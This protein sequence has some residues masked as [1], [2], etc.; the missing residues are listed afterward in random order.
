MAGGLDQSLIQNPPPLGAA[1]SSP[2]RERGAAVAGGGWRKSGGGCGTPL[3]SRVFGAILSTPAPA[4]SSHRVWLKAPITPCAEPAPSRSGTA[5]TGSSP[6][7][8]TR[9]LRS[10]PCWAS[11][12][13]SAAADANAIHTS[14]F[15]VFLTLS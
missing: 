14:L 8:L 5:I 15:I 4:R 12:V 7:L 11:T 9:P 1:T 13:I 6:A 10:G 2:C 3:G